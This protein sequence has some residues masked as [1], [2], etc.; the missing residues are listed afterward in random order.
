MIT[1]TQ[2]QSIRRWD[3]LSD[4]L[5]EFMFAETTTGMI[6]GIFASL[7]IPDDKQ[8][9]V[10][11]IVGW[12]LMGFVHIED[13]A[14]EIQDATGINSQHALELADSIKIKIFSPFREVLEKIYAL[15]EETPISRPRM[16]SIIAPP[17]ATAP[18]PKSL[19]V[20]SAKPAIAPAPA[21]PT[22]PATAPAV[23]PKFTA[24][25]SPLPPLGAVP[26]KPASSLPVA[27]AVP[28][29]AVTLAPAP[30]MIHAETKMQPVV[31]QAPKFTMESLGKAVSAFGG[32]SGA[33]MAPPKLAQVEIGQEEKQKPTGV[34]GKYESSPRVIHYSNLSTPL[35]AE[36]KGVSSGPVSFGALQG[37][38]SAPRPAA[39]PAAAIPAVPKT[40]SAPMPPGTG[41]FIKTMITPKNENV[42]PLPAPALPQK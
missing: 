30:F 14:K 7:H 15:P 32:K 22:K 18:G 3:T 27:P 35:P 33:S 36:T 40:P 10:R 31:Q 5:K 20:L 2:Q 8:R 41:G 9:P 42:A 24:T 34:V 16:D 39:P 12:A 21:I 6:D 19:E 37:I 38:P 25:P 13:V 29:P 26:A 4:E 11:R 23:S 1:I 28:A 17:S